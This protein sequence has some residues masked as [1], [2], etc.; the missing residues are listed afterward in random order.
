LVAHVPAAGVLAGAI[1]SILINLGLGVG[2]GALTLE[3]R[4]TFA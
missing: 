3:G 1:I 4:H 2:L